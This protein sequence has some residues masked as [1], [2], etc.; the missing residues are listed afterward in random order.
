M[1]SRICVAAYDGNID[2]LIG[3]HIPLFFAAALVFTLLFL[4]YT[5]LLL[6]G[7][8]LQ[9]KSHLEALLMG[10]QCQAETIHR[11]LP[12]SLQ[13]KTS[14]LAWT[15]AYAL[16]CVLLIV[17]AFNC[18]QDPSVNLLAILVG[19]GIL[20]LWAWVSGGVYKNWCLDA[21]EGS[22]MLNLIVLAA[23]TYHVN[24]SR[25]DHRLLLGTPLSL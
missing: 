1:Y 25:G 8:W 24:H 22:F 21:L 13:S 10:Q 11:F 18:Q 5:L 2:Y 17:F 9:A 14:L 15:A 3:I 19:T 6:F 4:P 12:C 23:A 20:H 16:R 7:Q